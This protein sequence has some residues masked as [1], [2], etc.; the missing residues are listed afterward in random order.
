MI[1]E[2]QAIQA[3]RAKADRALA[4]Y[5]LAI[6]N[7]KRYQD[8]EDRARDDWRE[9]EAEHDALVRAWR[10]REREESAQEMLT[11]VVSWTDLLGVKRNTIVAEDKAT[12][13]V[14][15][16]ISAGFEGIVLDGTEQAA[17]QEETS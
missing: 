1:T 2:E 8:V 10:L 4:D 7:T 16:L 13:L 3:A 12:A 14:G 11:A 9:S 5:N 6:V 15:S 17:P